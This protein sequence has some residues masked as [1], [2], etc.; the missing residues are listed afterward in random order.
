VSTRAQAQDH[1]TL[2]DEEL[3]WLAQR[4]AENVALLYDRY[5]DRVFR[6]CWRRLGRREDAEVAPMRLLVY[7][8]RVHA[9]RFSVGGFAE[10]GPSVRELWRTDA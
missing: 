8:S 10:Y 3:A 5:A 4:A 7:P 1:T 6:A 2:G 9:A